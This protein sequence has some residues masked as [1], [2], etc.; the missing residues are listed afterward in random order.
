M[1]KFMISIA[2]ML[3]VGVSMGDTTIKRCDK[4]GACGSVSDKFCFACGKDFNKIYNLNDSDR[5]P[6]ISSGLITPFKF[7]LIAPDVG[8]PWDDSCTV[9]GFDGGLFSS[10][11]FS[12]WGVGVSGLMS[13]AQSINGLIV[14][15][16]CTGNMYMSGIVLS[17]FENAMIDLYGI[18][19]SGLWN[20]AENVYGVQI[21]LR[22]ISNRLKGIQVAGIT[23]DAGENSSG[24]QIGIVNKMGKNSKGLQLGLLNWFDDS[25][26]PL[27]NMRF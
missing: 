24:V 16:G 5:Y 8:I 3:T 14:T 27:L 21:G 7:S 10:K 17:G 18:A 20:L 13:T 26:C 1:C 4:C 9:C 23:N 15:G 6:K 11:N 2:M 19:V 12:V 22:N 25:C